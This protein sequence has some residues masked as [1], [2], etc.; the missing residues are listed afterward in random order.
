MS[1]AVRLVLWVLAIAALVWVN[2]HVDMC[3]TE[4]KLR[5]IDGGRYE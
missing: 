5:K 3:H 4:W 2:Y 1:R